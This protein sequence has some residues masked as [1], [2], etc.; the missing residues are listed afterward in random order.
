MKRI[1]LLL[2]LS[3]ILLWELPAQNIYPASA[4]QM[5]FLGKSRSLREIEASRTLDRTRTAKSKLRREVP[6]E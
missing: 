6:K 1:F 3:Q 2:L 5:Q 4:A